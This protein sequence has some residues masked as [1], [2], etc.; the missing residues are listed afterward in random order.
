MIEEDARKL[1]EWIQANLHHHAGLSWSEAIKREFAD[2]R[3]RLT[4][5]EQIAIE[6]GQ[7]IDELKS[8][9]SGRTFYCVNCEE[10][11]RR[12]KS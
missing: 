3:L 2:L 4:E 9:L 5:T 10:T 6:R 1:G 12:N 11:A 8:Q 7:K